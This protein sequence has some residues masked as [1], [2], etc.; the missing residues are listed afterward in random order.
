M[1]KVKVGVVGCGVIS[2]VYLKNL[3]Q[4]YEI[5]EVKACADI[6]FNRAKKQAE[7]FNISAAG[8]VD[9]LIADPEIEIVVNLTIPAVHA[10]ICLQALNAG[11]NVY[12]E[13]ALALTLEDGQRVLDLAKEKGLIVGCAPDTLLGGGMQTCRKLIKDG[14][15]GKP[16]VAC[17]LLISG[18]PESWH[19]DPEFFYKVG[20]GPLFDMGPYYIS[21]LVTILGPVKRVTGSAQM[22][23]PT[24]TITS[25]P[26]FGNTINVEVPT[27]IAAVLDFEGGA[28]ATL[29]TSFDTN[30]YTPRL[31]IFGSQG[32]MTLSDPNLFTG[33]ILVKRTG[34]ETYSEV[35]VTFGYHTENFRGI[36]VADMAYALR[37]GRKHRATGELAYHVLDVMHCIQDSSREG[38]HIEVKSTCEIPDALPMGLHH[39]VLD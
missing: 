15:I 27:N 21:A 25:R 36:G 8:S 1:K 9:E 35:P 31:E 39:G 23:Y 4:T 22:T 12:V 28:I 29:I 30:D 32:N 34:T 24:R 10:K 7:A 6:D 37:T 3:T 11:K 19:Q 13:K 2:S 14:W 33:P 18:G 17:G 20:A 38:R 5:L 26:K 16:A